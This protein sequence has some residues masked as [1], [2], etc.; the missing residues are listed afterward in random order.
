MEQKINFEK[1]WKC[2]KVEADWLRYYCHSDYKTDPFNDALFYDRIQS[3][4][5]TKKVIPLS[6][7]CSMLNITSD[8]PVLESDVTDLVISNSLRDHSKNI[9]TALEWFLAKNVGT[10][11]LLQIILK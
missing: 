11:Q 9:Y 8:K 6:Q 1:L 5:Y 7:R 2:A 4:G 10:E 3:I